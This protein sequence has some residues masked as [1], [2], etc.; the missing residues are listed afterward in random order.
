MDMDDYVQVEMYD[1][2]SGCWITMPQD[3]KDRDEALSLI[4]SFYALGS[5]GNYRI[6]Q[7]T[8]HAAN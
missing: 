2:V 6:V 5:N 8:Y 1:E 4:D 7:V 3:L